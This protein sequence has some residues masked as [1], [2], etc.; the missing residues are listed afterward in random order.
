MRN[1]VMANIVSVRFS[2]IISQN[3]N[4][5]LGNRWN[6]Y[7]TDVLYKEDNFQEFLFAFL[8]I[9]PLMKSDVV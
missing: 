1:C 7:I 3:Y 4:K 5:I 8:E 9:K 2:S 6:Q